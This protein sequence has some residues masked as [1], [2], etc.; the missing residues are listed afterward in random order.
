MGAQWTDCPA[1]D[2]RILQTAIAIFPSMQLD[3]R[4][5]NLHSH[6]PSDERQQFKVESFKVK[7]L[8]KTSG[9]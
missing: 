8:E 3:V 7:V 6:P 4:S 1:T 9:S 2:L 5:N